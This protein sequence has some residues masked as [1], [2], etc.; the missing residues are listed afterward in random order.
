MTV[1]DNGSL[2][3]QSIIPVDLIE[4]LNSNGEVIV[5]ITDAS[6]LGLI[7]APV[8]I[9]INN[10]MYICRVSKGVSVN[11]TAIISVTGMI[12]LTI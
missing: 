2:I 4:W 9:S 3:C 1:G 11:K 8:H 10:R 5:S 7:F 6:E 12:I